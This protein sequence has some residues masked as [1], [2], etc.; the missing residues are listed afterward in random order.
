MNADKHPHIVEDQV[1]FVVEVLRML[2]GP[3][4][5]Q[6]LWALTDAE[7]SVKQLA[8]AVGKPAPLRGTIKEI[9]APLSR[10]AADSVLESSAVGIRA[11]TGL[12]LR[13]RCS[14]RD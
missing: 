13:Q 14:D 5:I 7:I 4:R 10:D 12:L 6:V 2:A 11:V 3:T 8:E 1:W 9:F